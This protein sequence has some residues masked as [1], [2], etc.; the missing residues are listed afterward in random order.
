MEL[1]LHLLLGPLLLIIMLVVKRNPPKKINK[2]YGYRTRRSMKNQN[3][4]DESN[5]FST[6]LMIKSAILTIFFQIIA[7]LIFDFQVAYIS[8]I[9]F[10][11][12]A[13]IITIPLTERHL[14]K[15]FDKDGNW[16]EP[17][18]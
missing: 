15:L 2:L 8:S 13:L 18:V 14:K 5:Q 4:W 12:V 3:T 9:I 11:L 1:L 7:Y 10:L 6:E 17:F 16:R